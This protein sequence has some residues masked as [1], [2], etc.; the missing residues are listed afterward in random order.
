MVETQEKVGPSRQASLPRL[1]EML[2]VLRR[3]HITRG[4]TPK[5]L[6]RILEDMG[7]TY[8]KLGQLLSMRADLLPAAYCQEL[9]R[10]RTEVNPLPYQ[11]IKQ[12]IEAEYGQSVQSIFLSIDIVPLGSASIAQVHAATLKD[13]R[14]V[15][16]K[17][18]RPGIRQVMARDIVLMK[19]A[20]RILNAVSDLSSTVDLSAVVDEMWAAAQQEM[21]FLLE[22]AHMREFAFHQSGVAYAGCP[23][24]VDS[25]TTSRVLVMEYIDG[26]RIDELEELKR[27][28]YD[29]NEIGAKLAENYCK[30]VL[31][32]AFFHADPHPGNLWIRD[33]KIIFLDLGMM[34]RLS[35]RDRALLRDAF[36][37]VANHDIYTLKGVVLA[38]GEARQEVNHARLYAALDELVTRYGDMDVGSINLGSLLQEL[39]EIA[40]T[41]D[42]SMPAGIS[43]LARGIVT[44]EGVLRFCCP[45]IS[46]MQVITSHMVNARLEDWDIPQ[47]ARKTARSLYTLFTKGAQIPAQLSDVLKIAANGQGRV[48][49]ELTESAEFFSGVSSLLNRLILCLIIIGLLIASALLCAYGGNLGGPQ[50]LGLPWTGALGFALAFIL[51]LRL[52][53]ICRPHRK[54]HGGWFG[55]FFTKSSKTK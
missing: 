51:C 11:D 16:V 45:D 32:D 52:V 31:D 50:V 43:M 3:Y 34:G 23:Q 6:R 1:K 54:K 20:I 8:I 4:L 2:A 44:I 26:V 18:Q 14:R 17:V 35:A 22:A 21:D 27:R 25:L 13:H 36:G 42:I 15:V 53:F 30:Q 47:E 55:R 39:M 19:K 28:G 38:L 10:L 37:A 40:K 49:L 41:N 33:G 5:K 29:L 24:V 9:A 7:P 12:V 48:N 46:L